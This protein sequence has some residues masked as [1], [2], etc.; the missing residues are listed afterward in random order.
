MNAHAVTSNYDSPLRR[1]QKEATRRR[2]LDAAGRLMADR[3]LEDLSFTAIAKEAGVKDRTVYR[4]FANK[5]M[6]LEGL[7]GW[8]QHR[9]NYGPIAETEQDLL[10]KP[11]R[12]FAG[13]DEN[14]KLTRALWSSPQGREFRLSNVEERKAGIKKAVA[15]ATRGLP[16]RQA[17]WLA[18]VIHVLYSGA[19][20]STM[21]DY[22]GLSGA[23]AGRASALAIELLLNSAR[24][25]VAP[26]DKYRKR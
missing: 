25:N 6:L 15:D 9:I 23:D 12:I 3:G 7:W 8:Y 14:E 26:I 19:A 18:A 13:F 24:N 22:W 20:W 1:E 5:S 4:H 11:L 21:K 16:S 2:I 17:K 10:E